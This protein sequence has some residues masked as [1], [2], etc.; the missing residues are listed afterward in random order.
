MRVNISLLILLTLG[1]CGD[2][3]SPTS[4]SP[5]LIAQGRWSGSLT[6][7][8]GTT[9]TLTLTLTQDAGSNAISGTASLSHP[10][11]SIGSGAVSGGVTRNTPPTD[12]ALS[13][14]AGG[15]CPVSL[16]LPCAFP[17]RT[18]LEGT[19]G[20]GNAACDLSLSG[21]FSLTKQ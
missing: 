6:D 15:A 12:G 1:A 5:T 7:N 20:G 17:T 4:P 3:G 9:G 11:L 2:G 8:S 21:N 19:I 13:I 18:R 10:A 14:A 16:N